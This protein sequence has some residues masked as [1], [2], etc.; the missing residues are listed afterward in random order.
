[1]LRTA[2]SAAARSETICTRAASG[3]PERV[4]H[5]KQHE[6]GASVP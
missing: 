3:S 1:M 2:R 4:I 5:C 6:A